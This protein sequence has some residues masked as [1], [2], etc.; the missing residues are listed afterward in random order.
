MIRRALAGVVADPLG[1]AHNAMI[2]EVDLA[3]KT[4]TAQVSRILRNGEQTQRAGT[5]TGTTRGSRASRRRPTPA[6]PFVL[7]VEH[8]GSGGNMQAAP[9][10]AQAMREYFTRVHQEDI[11]PQGR[12][13]PRDPN[14]TRVD[15]PARSP[16]KRCTRRRPRR[17]Q[18]PRSTRD[19][20][21]QRQAMG[22]ARA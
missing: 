17:P 8:G 3:G 15:T 6:W 12:T 1:T 11:G 16:V 10:I 5:P 19:G 7:L 9:L 18:R 20:V 2:S 13:P 22:A 21:S 14:E 4:G